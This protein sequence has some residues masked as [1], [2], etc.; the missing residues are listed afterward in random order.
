MILLVAG[1]IIRGQFA[2]VT[3]TFIGNLKIYMLVLFDFGSVFGNS[4]ARDRHERRRLNKCSINQGTLTRHT[5]S[6]TV[7]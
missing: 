4:W 6:K 5:D 2:S 3:K 1:P 7:S